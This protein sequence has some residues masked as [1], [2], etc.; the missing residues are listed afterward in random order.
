MHVTGQYSRGIIWHGPLPLRQKLGLDCIE[1]LQ[2]WGYISRSD[3]QSDIG[4]CSCWT[5]AIEVTAIKCNNN[6]I[7]LQQVK[8]EG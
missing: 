4:A 6:K 2:N 8:V 1:S 5:H 3:W 7:I